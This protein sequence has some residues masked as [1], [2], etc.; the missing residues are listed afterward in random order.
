MNDRRYFE[1][2]KICEDEIRGGNPGSVRKRLANLNVAKIPRP[3]RRALAALA[4]RSGHIQLGLKILSPLIHPDRGR[5]VI[6]EAA[7]FAEYGALLQQNGSISEAM[8]TLH[9]VDTSKAPEAHLFL[10]FCFF[11]TWDYESAILGL[12]K[13]VASGLPAYQ[14]LVG[15]VNLSAALAATGREDEALSLVASALDH[16]AKGNHFRLQANLLEIR[17]QILIRQLQLDHAEGE[18]KRALHIFNDHGVHDQLFIRM[19]TSVIEGMRTGRAEPVLLF[20]QEAQ[21]RRHWESVR[22]SDLYAL[23]IS[24]ENGRFHRL[25]YGTPHRS[26][27]QRIANELG[28]E[29]EEDFFLHGSVTDP[30]MDVRTGE[31]ERFAEPK[32]GKKTHQVLKI[33]LHDLYRP[34]RVGSLFAELFPG[35]YFNPHSSPNR[36]HQ[37]LKRARRYIHES[38]LPLKIGVV[39]GQYYLQKTGPFAFRLP[40][41]RERID[42]A[43]ATLARLRAQFPDSFTAREARQYAGISYTTMNGWISWALKNGHIISAGR[44]R[45]TR[46]QFTHAQAAIQ[47]AV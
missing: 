8:S 5:L 24:F 10:A 26:F 11:S 36:V 45:L 7:E 32:P 30:C 12:R 3:F 4:R 16:A 17:A 39:N 42:V 34:Q 1:L 28:R 35:E 46:Y 23:K 44:G 15:E 21:R 38:G 6:P 43:H 47:S 40:K 22:E 13:Y 33:L 25:Y 31:I 27:R 2:I 41:H 9:S 19:W 20:Q 29:P 37:C 18:L 14:T